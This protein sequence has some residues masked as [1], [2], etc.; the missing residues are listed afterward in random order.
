MLVHRVLSIYFVERNISTNVKKMSASRT[1]RTCG[2]KP[3]PSLHTLY[4]WESCNVKIVFAIYKC[5]L[6]LMCLD[7]LWE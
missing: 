5:V 4:A 7:R 2:N 6:R 3:S 1:R